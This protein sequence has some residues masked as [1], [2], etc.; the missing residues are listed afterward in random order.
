[1]LC[2]L[3]GL[4]RDI[5]VFSL[6]DLEDLAHTSKLV[7]TQE[8]YKPDVNRHIWENRH[9]VKGYCF[10]QIVKYT[11]IFEACKL[12]SEFAVVVYKLDYY[13]TTRPDD[14]TLVGKFYIFDVP[15]LHP[16]IRKNGGKLKSML[17]AE[18]LMDQIL[19]TK[20]FVDAFSDKNAFLASQEKE[21][22]EGEKKADHE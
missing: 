21:A 8:Y 20:R 15:A 4:Y 11:K 9:I 19:N 18:I 7:Q 12:E 5:L 22:R 6:C 16:L 10:L 3:F 17:K 14:Y 13:V 1:M 2:G